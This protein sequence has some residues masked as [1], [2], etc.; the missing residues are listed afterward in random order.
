MLLLNN[1]GVLFNIF[2]GNYCCKLKEI[3][4]FVIMT[5]LPWK[6]RTCKIKCYQKRYLNF[7][8]MISLPDE[9]NHNVAFKFKNTEG[10][11]TWQ[12]ETQKSHTYNSNAFISDCQGHR[13]ARSLF[14]DSN[15]NHRNKTI[16]LTGVPNQDHLLE[17]NWKQILCYFP[18]YNIFIYVTFIRQW[19]RF[20]SSFM[21]LYFFCLHGDSK[22]RNSFHLCVWL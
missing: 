8:L 19:Y 5:F 20:N 17:A 16:I 18:I 3:C 9:M 12:A 10:K 22:G 4:C 1:I 7:S 6:L 2:G 14:Q 21:I 13:L 15:N 11:H